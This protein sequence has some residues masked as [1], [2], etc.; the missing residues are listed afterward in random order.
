VI[1]KSLLFRGIAKTNPLSILFGVKNLSIYS[2]TIEKKLSLAFKKID[3]L[4]A[5]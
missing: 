3:K 1:P 5:V 4:F 2:K